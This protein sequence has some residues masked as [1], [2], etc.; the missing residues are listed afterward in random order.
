MAGVIK[1][2]TRGAASKVRRLKNKKAAHTVRP[3]PTPGPLTLALT[4]PTHFDSH[5]KGYFACV[6][7][8]FTC[9]NPHR[10]HIMVSI[11]GWLPKG[12]PTRPHRL[13]TAINEVCGP[14][15]S[16]KER[17]T[18]KDGPKGADTTFLK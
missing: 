6:H 9:L 15:P 10:L 2:L 18:S 8:L 1:P 7:S 13:R 17:P 11:Q 3:A 16:D 12:K 14:A 4:F 5:I